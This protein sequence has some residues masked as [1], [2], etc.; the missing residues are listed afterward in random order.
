MLRDGDDVNN[1]SQTNYPL[2]SEKYLIARCQSTIN[3]DSD[4]IYQKHL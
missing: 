3:E 1:I 4:D 2:T